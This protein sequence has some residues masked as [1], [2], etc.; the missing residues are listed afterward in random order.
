MSAELIPKCRPRILEG[1]R[2]IW[3]SEKQ[4]RVVEQA[5]RK[6]D[7]LNLRLNERGPGGILVVR[8]PDHRR[9]Q[10]EG[11]NYPFPT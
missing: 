7:R 1:I 5:D 2:V 3:D 9:F 11:K 10:V 4:R 6:S 8:R